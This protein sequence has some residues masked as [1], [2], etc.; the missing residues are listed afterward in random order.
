MT[1]GANA[2][3]VKVNIA[4]YVLYMRVNSHVICKM[5]SDVF[6]RSRERYDI[7]LS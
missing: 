6:D 7:A 1:K 3:Y 5:E 2:P 4:S